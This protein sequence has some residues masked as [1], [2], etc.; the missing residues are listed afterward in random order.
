MNLQVSE[1]TSDFM[2]MNIV[3]LAAGMGK[4]MKSD[5]PKV[6]HPIAGRPVL[7][8]CDRPRR[9]ALSPGAD[10]RGPR[11]RRRARARGRV[12]TPTS[13][14]RCNRRRRAP[15]MQ[16]QQAVPLLDALA[17]HLWCCSGTFR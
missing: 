10:H 6:L 17:A 13:H 4:R 11:P 3:V 1:F 14:G 9:S 8:S 12:G 7:A 16:L 2:T 5:L 15:G